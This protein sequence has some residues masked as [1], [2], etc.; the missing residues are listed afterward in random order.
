M[1]PNEAPSI[2]RLGMIGLSEGNGHPVSFTSIINGF[3][4]EAFSILGWPVIESYL[5][6]RAPEDI[7]IAGA[8]VTSVWNQD[9]AFSEKLARVCKIGHVCSSLDEM[10]SNVDAVI[11]ARDDYELHLEMAAPFLDAG[12]PVFIDKPLA[13]SSQDLRA[14]R[15]SAW[16]GKIASFSGA[17]KAIELDSVRS[18]QIDFGEIKLV[19]GTVLNSWLKYGVHM[20]DAIMGAF[21]NVEFQAVRAIKRAGQTHYFISTNTFDVEIV[22][23]GSIGKTFQIDIFATKQNF[24]THIYDNFAMFRRTLEWFVSAMK[25]PQKESILS[26]SLES[27]F[28][29]MAVLSAGVESE[30]S[31]GREISLKEV[32]EK[33]K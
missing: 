17:K 9:R 14:F 18:G 30:I 5:K 13:V 16:K 33:F 27:T 11:L 25:S 4:E 6:R 20:I 21:P 3:D 1:K 26:R 19:R 7:G 29:V 32:Y 23:L 10:H 31:G 24:T 12:I 15:K 28:N 8:K 22:P 2:L